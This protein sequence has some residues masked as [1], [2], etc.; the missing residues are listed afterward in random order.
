MIHDSGHP[1]AFHL[2]AF[3]EAKDYDAGSRE[4]IWWLPN[5]TAKDFF[6]LTNNSR[7]PIVATLRLFDAK[8]K[9]SAQQIVLKP[10]TTLRNSVR[11]LLQ[12]AGLTCVLDFSIF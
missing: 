1:V 4:G 2:D 6:I 7:Q 10:K 5:R 12:K 11:E 3:V 9:V 8:G